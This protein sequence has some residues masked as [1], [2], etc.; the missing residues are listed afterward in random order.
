MPTKL[1]PDGWACFAQRAPRVAEVV[2]ALQDDPTPLVAALA[3]TPQTLV[4]G[5]WKAGNL[6]RDPDGRTILLD[7]AV[8]GIAPPCVDIA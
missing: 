3:T 7:W 2:F 6:G 1:M 4:H 8:P 5:D